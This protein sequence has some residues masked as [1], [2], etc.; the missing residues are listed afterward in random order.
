MSIT[1]SS[2]GQQA[3]YAPF[4]WIDVSNTILAQI[5]QSGNFACTGNLAIGGTLTGVTTITVTTVTATTVNAT[6]VNATTATATT[7]NAGASGTAG[8][9]QVFPTTASKGKATITVS[10]ASGNTT[11][12]INVAAQTGARTYTV[13]DAGAS[14]SFAMT[15]GAQTINGAKTFGGAAIFSST[16]ATGAL[17]VTGAVTVS[18]TLGVTGIITPTGGVAAAGG[19]STSPRNWHTG[20][21][22][23]LA[24]T[25]GTD[26]TVVATEVIIAEVFVPSNATITGVA[27]FNGSAVAGNVKVGLANSAG[28]VV[29]TSA[30]TAQSGTDAYQLV[31]FTGTYAAVGPATYYVLAIGDTGGGTSKINTHIIGSFGGSKQTGQVYATGFTTITPPTTFTTALAPMASLY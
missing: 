2:V 3:T 4:Q 9:F 28:A 6:T 23:P 15:E 30:S 19:F 29:A 12:A 10:D 14:A 21:S 25:D 5:D 11:T 24:T 16:V 13:P 22:K 27:L 20:A 1:L 7:V 17:T 31:P 26:Y 8:T 18:T